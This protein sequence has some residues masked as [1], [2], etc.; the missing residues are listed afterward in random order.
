M[1]NNEFGWDDLKSQLPPPKR[2]F[3]II[4]VAVLLIVGV[5][6]VMTSYYTVHADEEAV[7]LRLGSYSQTAG[8][9]FHFK[10]PFFL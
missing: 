5:W 9:G 6:G 4:A 10:L 8:P 1:S 3:T 2:I 7:I